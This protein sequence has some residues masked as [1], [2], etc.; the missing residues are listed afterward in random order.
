MKPRLAKLGVVLTPSHWHVL[1][2]TS[3]HPAAGSRLGLATFLPPGGPH[4]GT[5]GTLALPA[6]VS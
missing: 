4:P 1:S 6:L 3:A 5:A 2:A